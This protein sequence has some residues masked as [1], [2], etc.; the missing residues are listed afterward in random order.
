VKLLYLPML[1]AV[2]NAAAL[3]A[4]PALL[5]LVMPDAKV[6]AGIEVSQAQ[7]SPF[8]QY[9]LSRVPRGGFDPT[10]SL[11][12]LVMATE[13]GPKAPSNRWL[14]AGKGTLDVE[15]LT[16][17]AQAR[18]GTLT[19]FDGVTIITRPADLAGQGPTAMAFLDQSTG[20]MGDIASVQTAIQQW[21][22]HAAASSSLLDK[23]NQASAN[24]DF[25]FVSL[26][27][28]SQFIAG[29]PNSN[30]GNAMNA[31]VLAA[32]NQLSGGVHFG[33][34]VALSV[35]AVARSEK[36]AQALADVLRFVTSLAQLNHQ[37]NPVAGQI[38]TLLETLQLATVANVTTV[39]LMVPEQALEQLLASGP[40]AAAPTPRARR[41]AN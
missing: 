29:L 17:A 3:A 1:V 24:N 28:P 15:K 5:G 14:M 40:L 25:W 20:V 4:D 18:G 11:N 36:D 32:I 22:G 7:S 31:N 27:P 8:G 33:D 41:R 34:S 13:G 10:R 37:N 9:L 16:A 26:V 21:Q 23:V 30:L 2:L 38:A 12:E 39:S 19:S 35:K 6:V